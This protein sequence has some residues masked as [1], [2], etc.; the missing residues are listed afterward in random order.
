MNDTNKIA[1]GTAL[2]LSLA[3]SCVGLYLYYSNP[4]LFISQPV[5]TI[6][7]SDIEND[8]ESKTSIEADSESSSVAKAEGWINYNSSQG[9]SFDYP[10]ETMG[11]DCD[12]KDSVPVPVKTFEDPENGYVYLTVNCEDTLDTL[13][14]KTA[15]V[16]TG[17]SSY[18]QEKILGTW[19]IAT[20][21]VKNEQEL[22]AFIKKHYGTGGCSM[23]EKKLTNRQNDVYEVTITGKD[24]NTPTDGFSAS[25]SCKV[26]YAY[27]IF[28]APEKNEVVSVVLGQDCTFNRTDS[29]E[30]C[31][32]E[33]DRIINSITFN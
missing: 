2:I 10:K 18:K 8:K 28:Y 16:S 22:S 15:Q 14:K 24:W 11:T 17:N 29:I 23:G 6:E 5:V 26:D 27:K 19:I 25:R 20:A 30:D 3:I 33:E 1:L 31:Y 21:E 12:G 32:E 13:Q 9:I 4:G 7:E